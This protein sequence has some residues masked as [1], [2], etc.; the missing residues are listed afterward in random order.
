[1]PLDP[2]LIAAFH[3]LPSVTPK[4]LRLACQDKRLAYWPSWR[5]SELESWGVEP[6]R[7]RQIIND[8]PRMDTAWTAQ[9]LSEFQVTLVL[10]TDPAY[11]PQLLNIA[12]PPPVL[13]VR[14]QAAALHQPAVAIVGTRQASTYGLHQTEM[15]TTQLA[16]NG[17]SVI[18]GL[19]YG[20]DAA[21]HRAALQADGTTIAVMGTGI[22]L[23]YPWDHR[24]L[25]EQILPRGA[26]VSELPLGAEPE[27]HHFPQRNR[28]IAGLAQAVW[29]VEA[30]Q[31]SGALIT[32]KY[33]LE[34]NRD[35]YALPGDVHRPGSHGPLNWLRLGA[36]IGAQV[37]DFSATWPN[38]QPVG[39]TP[40]IAH[41][42]SADQRIILDRL[43]V[44]NPTH[45]D[46]IVIA[47]R[48]EASVI[49]AA[50]ALLEVRGLVRHHGDMRYTR[51]T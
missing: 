31:R 40:S 6:G 9:Q 24:Q 10:V 15:I 3:R 51:L 36:A 50:L 14:G 41:S 11:P 19:A 23:I 45:I 29:L 8:L 2:A 43:D 37:A 35:L 13:Y 12:Q 28:I 20:I 4:T 21:A 34:S 46:E 44:T 1:M 16:R 47:C 49:A 32:M 26:L 38:L 27:R 39:L 17:L 48:L 22:D 30:G 18:S 7:A 5:A 25:G 33:G 42:V